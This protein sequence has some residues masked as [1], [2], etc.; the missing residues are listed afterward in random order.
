MNG[1]E[2]MSHRLPWI[3]KCVLALCIT[4]A[5]AAAPATATAAINPLA[6]NNPAAD[7]T[8]QD[9]QSVTTVQALGNHVAVAFE[10]S[11]SCLDPCSLLSGDLTGWSSSR[12]SGAS[13]TDHGALA[14]GGAGDGGDPVLAAL[15]GTDTVY[16]ATRGS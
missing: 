3:R 4:A 7:S 13:F 6:V 2:Q 15:D 1:D 9:T 10:D 11:G 12:D 16:L 5:L 8:A 14:S